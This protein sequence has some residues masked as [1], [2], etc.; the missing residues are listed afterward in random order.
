MTDAPVRVRIAPSPTGYLHVGTARTA[1][2][3]YLF[4]RHAEGEFLIRVEDTDRERSRPELI[5]PIL[6]ALRWLRL[7]WDEGIVYQSKRADLYAKYLKRFIDTGQAYYC[8]CSQEELLAER[9][10]AR[11]EK[12][13]PK[14]NRKCLGLSVNEIKDRFDAGE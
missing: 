1:L 3:N 13:D 2:F 7:E 8:F 12:R 4:A 5:D 10:K 9:E 11:A 6:D 14:Y